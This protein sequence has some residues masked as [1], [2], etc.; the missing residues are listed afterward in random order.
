MEVSP[1]FPLDCQA[2]IPSWLETRCYR[3]PPGLRIA[4]TDNL[5]A[6]PECFHPKIESPLFLCLYCCP[7]HVTA[8]WSGAGKD[9]PS[10]ASL[11]LLALQISQR[12]VA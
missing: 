8:V 9:L 4:E 2:R 12:M 5:L 7:R 10:E 1:S 6:I 11:P 3:L